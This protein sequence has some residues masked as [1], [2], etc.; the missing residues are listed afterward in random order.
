MSSRLTILSVL[1]AAALAAA[2]LLG[3]PRSAPP[4][5]AQTGVGSITG[6][7]VWNSP[8]PMPYGGPAQS[9]TAAP[10]ELSPDANPETAPE[11]PPEA[12]PEMTS[13]PATGAMPAPGVQ[14]YPAPMPP[15]PIRP[16]A[17]RLIPAGA[18]LVAV[19]GTALSAR[20]DENGRFRIEGVPAGQYWTVAAGPVRGTNS[21]FVLRPNVTVQANKTSSLGILYLGQPYDSYVPVPYAAPDAHGG[22][23]P[24][25]PASEPDAAP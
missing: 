21:A 4:A 18:V 8:M 22:V 9:G 6:Q 2:L 25:T 7:V 11:D 5:S 12:S 19:Q 16:P 20:T 23:E 3:F 1:S 13:P 24:G 17:P 15:I 10:G 14:V